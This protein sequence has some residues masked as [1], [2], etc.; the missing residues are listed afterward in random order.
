[1]FK[2]ARR[3]QKEILSDVKIRDHAIT[4]GHYGDGRGGVKGPHS[5][6]P[7]GHGEGGGR[8]E[9]SGVPEPDR[10]IS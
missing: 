6:N 8:R 1:M 5:P 3:E 10:P 7:V 2:S 4:R 9:G